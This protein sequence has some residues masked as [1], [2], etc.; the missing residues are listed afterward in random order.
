MEL[1]KVIA[2]KFADFQNPFKNGRKGA[3]YHLEFSLP[4]FIEKPKFYGLEELGLK[5]AART[6]NSFVVTGV[7]KVAGD[8]E[9]VLEYLY[10]GYTQGEP[11]L[12]R[13][14]RFAINPD[15]RELWQDRP[16]PEGLEYPKENLESDYVLGVGDSPRMMVAA[17]RRGRSHAHHGL[18]RD[19]HFVIQYEVKSG[20]YLL[21]VADGAGSA[22]FSREGSRLACDAAIKSFSES[23]ALE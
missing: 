12:K 17:S 2:T 21:A 15:T 3:D 7:P 11:P 18:P 9:V 4:T 13:V 19:D 6:L 22:E 8:Q 5:L 1:A 20:Y 10:A 16:V 23:L 14:F